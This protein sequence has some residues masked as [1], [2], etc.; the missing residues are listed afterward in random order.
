M[1]DLTLYVT[2]AQATRIRAALVAR[3]KDTALETATFG[4][5]AREFMLSMVKDLVRGYERAAAAKQAEATLT[6]L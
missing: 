3:Y 6:E 4:A 2:N 5:Q 1:S